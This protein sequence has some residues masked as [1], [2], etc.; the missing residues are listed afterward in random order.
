MVVVSLESQLEWVMD[1]ARDAPV[2]YLHK[3][4][5]ILVIILLLVLKDG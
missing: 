3:C 4:V 1:E 2:E 5:F